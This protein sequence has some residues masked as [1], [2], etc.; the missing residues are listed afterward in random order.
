[1]RLPS[2]LLAAVALAVVPLAAQ[3]PV[4]PLDGLSGSEHWVVYDAMVASGR[5]DTST[6]YLYIGLNEPPKAEVLAWRAGQPFRREAVVHL[7]QDGRGYEAIVDLRAR[8]VLSWTEVPGRQMMANRVENDQ[9]DKL[10]MGD[11]RVRDA[12]RKRGVTDFTN[13]GCGIANHGYFDLPEERGRRV[14]HVTCGDDHGRIT[15]YGANLR[16]AGRGDRPDR[17]QDLA[18]HRYRG[19]TEQRGVR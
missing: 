5:T 7:V 1:M 16:G 4:H 12:I 2:L 3:A 19:P 17:R 14:V 15:G 18:G 10:A 11:Q 6:T 13:V 8:K 9:V